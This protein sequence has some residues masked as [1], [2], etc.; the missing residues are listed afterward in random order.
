MP[1]LQLKARLRL[2]LIE[3]LQLIDKVLLPAPVLMPAQLA[4]NGIEPAH[5]R[6][7]RDQAGRPALVPLQADAFCFRF[8]SLLQRPTC[9][10][11]TQGKIVP[12]GGLP[13][14]HRRLLVFELMAALGLAC[15]QGVDAIGAGLRLAEILDGLAVAGDKRFRLVDA[16]Q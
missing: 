12:L 2:G 15:F 6:Q 3:R 14:L 13:R 8:V 1:P 7:N 16:R 11:L 4:A 9:F 10:T 5:P